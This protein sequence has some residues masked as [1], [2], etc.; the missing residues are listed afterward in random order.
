MLNAVGMAFPFQFVPGSV[1]CSVRLLQV[2]P[3]VKINRDRHAHYNECT[4]S[5]DQKPPDHPHSRV[6]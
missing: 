3:Q 5:Q 4:D 6:G 2:A 1:M